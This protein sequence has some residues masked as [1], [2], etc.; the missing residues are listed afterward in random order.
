MA[1]QRKTVK[2][3]VRAHKKKH[4]T[5]RRSVNNKYKGGSAYGLVN[6]DNTILQGV[7]G[8]PITLSSVNNAGINSDTNMGASAQHGGGDYYGYN[9]THLN[10]YGGVMS[11][12][13]L[14][15]NVSPSCGGAKKRSVRKSKKNNKSKKNKKRKNTKKSRKGRRVRKMKGGNLMNPSP[16]SNTYTLNAGV[17]HNA[18]AN[19]MPHKTFV[20]CAD[21]YNH[22][23][24]TQK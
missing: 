22:F 5:K 7:K 18:L 3:S 8:T 6:V 13:E 23:E 12:T 2:K 19:P 4:N 15:K 11:V 24:A 9:P 14:T 10:E 17:E 20:N 1:K 16:F 21:N